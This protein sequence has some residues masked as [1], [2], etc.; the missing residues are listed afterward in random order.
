MF[1]RFK[2]YTDLI[3]GLINEKA[4]NYGTDNHAHDSVIMK[5]KS[6]RNVAVPLQHNV[7]LTGG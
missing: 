7:G 4:F 6:L 1:Y 5:S 2:L 3:E